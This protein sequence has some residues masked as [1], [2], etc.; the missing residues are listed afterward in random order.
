L[1]GAADLFV[2]CQIWDRRDASPLI[3]GF[4]NFKPIQEAALDRE[5]DLFE[6]FP[7]GSIVWRSSVVGHEKA[8]RALKELASKTSNECCVMYTPTKSLI[9]IMNA[10]T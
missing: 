8:I 10:S 7:D 5:Y 1:P 2:K 3:Q 9:A 4:G 6:K